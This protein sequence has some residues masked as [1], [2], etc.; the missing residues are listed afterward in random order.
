MLETLSTKIVQSH[1]KVFSITKTKDIR[2][3][4]INNNTNKQL[5]Y[6]KKVYSYNRTKYLH[7]VLC[8]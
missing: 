5:K 6:N 8:S 3:Y 4:E 2:H 1:P 7:V